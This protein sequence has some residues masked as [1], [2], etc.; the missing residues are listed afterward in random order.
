MS[1]A[2]LA[3]VMLGQPW[4]AAVGVFE[5]DVATL[6]GE[7]AGLGASDV[8]L[9]AALSQESLQSEPALATPPR[10]LAR[11]IDSAVQSSLRATVMITIDV[12]TKEPGAWRGVIRPRRR[13]A[14]WGAYRAGVLT[15]ARVAASAGADR[16]AIGSE[17]SSMSGDRDAHQWSRLAAAVRAVFAGELAYVANHD[18]LD[19]TAPFA[20]VDVAGISAYFPMAETPRPTRPMLSQR[21]RTLDRQLRTFATKVRRPIVLF[22]IG[23]PSVAGAAMTP[24]DDATGAPV[25]LEAQR[26]AYAAAVDALLESSIIRGAFFWRWSARGGPYDRS[27]SPRGKPATAELTRLWRLEIPANA[28]ER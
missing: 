13:R 14:W 1:G 27:H 23:Y 5:D 25:D 6:I 24:W 11:A 17:L 28:G 10:R 2:L 19:R 15:Y 20:H 22:E 8:L 18:A 16:L 26:L 3:A 9:P 12:Q 21:W 7:V 4:G